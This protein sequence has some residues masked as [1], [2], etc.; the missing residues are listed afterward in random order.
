MVI[1]VGRGRFEGLGSLGPVLLCRRV[2]LKVKA[3]ASLAAKI[4][5][6]QPNFEEQL[7]P[8]WPS[9]AAASVARRKW[10]VE[11]LQGIRKQGSSLHAVAV[12]AATATRP[13]TTSTA[14]PS[15]CL[16]LF[17]DWHKCG[18]ICHPGGVASPSLGGGRPPL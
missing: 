7:R 18:S 10:R 2:R 9:S 15:T 6:S 14:T 17:A 5:Q 11:Q 12:A 8:L 4:Q 13:I 1:V 3:L 16:Q